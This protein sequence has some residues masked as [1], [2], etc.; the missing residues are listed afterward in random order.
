LKKELKYSPGACQKRFIALQNDTATIP[1]EL[2]DDQVKRAEEK[3]SRVLA[4]LHARNLREATD[5]H[6]KEQ[7]RLAVENEKLKK[8]LEKKERADKR[9]QVAQENA[10]LAM[11]QAAK[12]E[13]KATELAAAREAHEAQI[14]ILR[15]GGSNPNSSGSRAKT[16]PKVMEKRQPSMSITPATSDMTPSTGRSRRSAVSEL[17]GEFVD[18]PR[19]RLS[20]K[21]LENL[22]I[23]RGLS[24]TG[25][26]TILMKRLTQDDSAMSIG[27]LQIKLQERNVSIEGTKAEL[28]ARLTSSD[29]AESAWGKK[30]TP[31]LNSFW[32]ITP[33][34]VK[35]AASFE[36]AASQSKRVCS[37]EYTKGEN[38]LGESNHPALMNL[39]V[40]AMAADATIT[41]TSNPTNCESQVSG[42]SFTPINNLE[43]TFLN[44]ETQIADADI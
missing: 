20:L 10:K 33:T 14:L 30:N 4:K 1:P 16:T 15:N 37:S 35:R 32:D 9:A 24:K 41:W 7:K 27:S 2:D 36:R 26:K 39:A 29:V 38:I 3:A 11:L 5:R 28:I 13:Q 31:A 6:A 34:S 21:E 40:T 8:A 43:N 22:C 19:S 17:I 23:K 12:R 44:F 42:A 25:S 18:S